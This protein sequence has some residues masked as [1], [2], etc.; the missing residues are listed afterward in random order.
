MYMYTFCICMMDMSSCFGSSSLLAAS[1]YKH[2]DAAN[3][4]DHFVCIL[5]YTECSDFCMYYCWSN[6]YKFLVITIFME[7]SNYCVHSINTVT[8]NW[9]SVM[10]SLMKDCN[11]DGPRILVSINSTNNCLAESSALILKNIKLTL[12]GCRC[13]ITLVISATPTPPHCLHHPIQ[14]CPLCYQCVTCPVQHTAWLLFRATSVLCTSE[15]LAANGNAA[16]CHH[17]QVKCFT[18]RAVQQYTSLTLVLT[19]NNKQGLTDIDIRP[20]VV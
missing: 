10:K 12:Q 9:W 1:K 7:G 8:L 14:S 20:S 13:L 18:L 16:I 5:R 17:L 15:P 19:V 4:L 6:L 3:R 11:F 2:L